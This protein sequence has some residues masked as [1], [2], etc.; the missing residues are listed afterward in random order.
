MAKYDAENLLAGIRSILSAKLNDAI[1]AVEAEKIAQGLPA[2]NIAPIDV[3]E[4]Y[5]EQT[6]SFANFNVKQGVY[7]GIEDMQA[8]GVG[9]ATQV[10]Y[11]VFIEIVFADGGN[12]KLGLKRLH[13]YTRAIQDVMEDN[14]DQLPVNSGKINIETIRPI[15]FKLEADSSEEIRVGGVSITMAIA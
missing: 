10:T 15:S 9:P 13:R 14:Y 1:A 4:G 5:F 11:K 6:W 8:K 2:T 3:N 12:D 7:Y